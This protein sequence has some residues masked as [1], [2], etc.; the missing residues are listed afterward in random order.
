MQTFWEGGQYA[1]LGSGTRTKKIGFMGFK[2]YNI[3]LYVEAQPAKAALQQTRL[4]NET[5]NTVCAALAQ[6]QFRKVVQFQ[7]L[8]D[9]TSTQF[10]DGLRENLVPNVKQYG[11]EKYLDTFMSFFDDKKIAKGTVIPLLWSIDGSLT[12]DVF[13]PG[14][15]QFSS[16]KPSLR[17]DSNAFCQAVFDIYLS[18]ESIVPDGRKRW[19]ASALQMAR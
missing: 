9:V 14:F 6:G 3:A 18:P 12:L 4:P 8:R 1:N 16:A 7:M 10:K 13:P 15:S 2:V 17:I 19:T 5:P 11:G